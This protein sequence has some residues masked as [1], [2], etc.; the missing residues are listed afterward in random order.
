MSVC[1]SLFDRSVHTGTG[2]NSAGFPFMTPN[3]S[4]NDRYDFWSLNDNSTWDSSIA[5][6]PLC[7]LDTENNQ[8]F[9]DPSLV[10]NWGNSQACT[11]AFKS[12]KYMHASSHQGFPSDSLDC[13]QGKESDGQLKPRSNA[14]YSTRCGAKDKSLSPGKVDQ[15]RQ[16]E[17]KRKRFLQ[18]NRAA[19]SKC[20]DK[21]REHM[22]LLETQFKEHSGKREKLLSEI[23]QLHAEIFGLKIESLTHS[24]CGDCFFNLYLRR[25]MNICNDATSEMVDVAARWAYNRATGQVALLL[26]SEDL[27]QLES[28][29]LAMEPEQQSH[30]N[31]E[32]LIFPL[33]PSTS[34]YWCQKLSKSSV[35]VTVVVDRWMT[36]MSS[37]FSEWITEIELAFDSYIYIGQ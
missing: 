33:G 12:Y 32:V 14:Q 18:R 6:P 17:M 23:S 36:R 15:K 22:K 29:D 34:K 1:R 3:A 7:P 10:H 4:L 13:K 28:L 9:T 24:Q 31:P 2:T 16:E 21:K 20:R 8:T 25:I 19:A 37:A 27:P 35:P 30:I 5:F 26:G 11:D